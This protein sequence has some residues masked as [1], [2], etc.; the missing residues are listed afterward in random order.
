MVEIIEAF[1][2]MYIGIYVYNIHY[3]WCPSPTKKASANQK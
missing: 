1:I 3:K 2:H